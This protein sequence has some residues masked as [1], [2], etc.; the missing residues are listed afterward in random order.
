MTEFLKA[1]TVI[2]CITTYWLGGQTVAFFDRGFKFIRRYI[3]PAG[4]CLFLIALGA[5][6]WKA[7]LACGLLC[8]ATHIGYQSRVW[9]YAMTGF[10]MGAPALILSYP[11]FNWMAFFPMTYHTAYGYISLKFNRFSWAF[12]AIAMG[13]GIGFAYVTSATMLQ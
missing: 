11:R 7:V 1:I 13:M 2:F 6:W 4:L 12:V 9:K 10:L 5:V 8:A 3:M